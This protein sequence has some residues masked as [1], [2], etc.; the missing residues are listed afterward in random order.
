MTNKFQ[1]LDTFS[2]RDVEAAIARNADDELLFVPITVALAMD[3]V[4]YAQLVCSRLAAHG[5]AAV[6][7]N[8]V[9]S[10]GHL[11]R[12]FRVLDEEMVR[13]IVEAALMDE[14]EYVR[15]SAKSAADEIHQFLGWTFKGHVYGI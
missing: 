14:D 3:D 10:F 13:P 4:A 8:A 15:M 7:G 11:A 5:Q 9:M 6:R 12:R 1:D 2:E